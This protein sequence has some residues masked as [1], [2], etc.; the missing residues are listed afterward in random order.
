M[1]ASRISK[2]F[3]TRFTRNLRRRK[4]QTVAKLQGTI[5]LEINFRL[6]T[7]RAVDDRRPTQAGRYFE[8]SRDVRV[9]LFPIWPRSTLVDR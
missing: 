5:A 6:G 1:T 2:G 8:A 4:A 7:I 9:L 3:K